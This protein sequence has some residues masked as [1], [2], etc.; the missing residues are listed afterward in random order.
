MQ[1]EANRMTNIAGLTIS[2]TKQSGQAY[3][4]PAVVT[5]N[6]KSQYNDDQISFKEIQN[7]W[8]LPSNYIYSDVP[9]ANDNS[10]MPD[11]TL[12]PGDVVGVMLNT[13]PKR[14]Q[15]AK[16]GSVYYNLGSIF[17]PA[18]QQPIAAQQAAPQQPQ[19]APSDG[20]QQ[21]AAPAT[22]G[23]LSLDERIAKAQAAN[24]LFD[25]LN[26]ADD[27]NQIQLLDSMGFGDYKSAAN[28]AA[29]A[30]QALRDGRSPFTSEPEPT[31]QRTEDPPFASDL[32]PVTPEQQ[33]CQHTDFTTA[34]QPHTG[35]KPGQMKAQCN[36]CFHWLNE[37]GKA[38]AAGET[39]AN[40][41]E[42]EQVPW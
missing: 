21:P 37:E 24:L 38:P 16:P 34:P 41:G 20:W 39:D 32:P 4:E 18:G 9:R 29:E 42:P 3:Y 2:D 19:S 33:D 23:G 15:N 1:R 22:G 12:R 6:G 17:D 25:V 40:Y 26:S 11:G 27:E 31:A 35:W 7:Y 10:S 13:N 36:T 8:S 5:V 28:V 30:W 14:G